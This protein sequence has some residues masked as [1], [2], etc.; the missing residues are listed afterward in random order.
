MKEFLL[1]KQFLTRASQSNDPSEVVR[2][3]EEYKPERNTKISGTEC[4]TSRRSNL[5]DYT[6]IYA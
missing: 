5:I 1:S 3:L 6:Q 2:S 4:P